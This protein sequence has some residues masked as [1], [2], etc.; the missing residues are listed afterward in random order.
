MAPKKKN[1][2]YGKRKKQSKSGGASGKKSVLKRAA[3][4]RKSSKARAASR[5]RRSRGKGEII[6][7][8][9][10]QPRGLGARSGGQSGDLQGL[11]GVEGAASESVEELLEEGNSF[12]ADIVKGVEDAQNADESEVETHEVPEDDVPEEYRD[13]K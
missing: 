12:E 6:D 9:V 13:E 8:V 10:F 4:K 2:R 11:S 1:T 7:N 5:K 3:A